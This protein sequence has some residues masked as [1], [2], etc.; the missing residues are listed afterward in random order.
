[1][2]VG[3]E[4]RV[5]GAGA[6]RTGTLSLQAALEIVGYGPCY[7]MRV[8]VQNNHQSRWADALNG[9]QSIEK[10]TSILEGYR[11]VVDFPASVAY[12]ELLCA[13]PEAKVNSPA[14]ISIP[15]LS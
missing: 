2:S 15:C 5:I 10:Y 4:I 7:H 3:P 11:S 1:M 14:F 13:Y 12:E 8:A 9:V 6:G